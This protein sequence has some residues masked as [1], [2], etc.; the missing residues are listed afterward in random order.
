MVWLIAALQWAHIL[1]AIAWFGGSVAVAFLVTPAA[2]R[3]SPDDQAGWWGAF[4]QQS[5]RYFATMAGATILLGI[6][7][8]IAGGVFSTLT[9]A[10]GLTW[11]ASLIVSIALAAWGA[12]VTNKAVLR[13]AQSAAADR[14]ASV[15]R[16]VR[17]GRIEL[18][19]FLLVFTMMIA[20][21]FG[22]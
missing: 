18:G 2:A 9:S 6:V 11:I 7:R 17:F 22:Y 3:L 1:F 5:V 13:I 19:G 4:S 8:G 16:A 12:N 10:Y 15:D 14:P 21:R 20:M